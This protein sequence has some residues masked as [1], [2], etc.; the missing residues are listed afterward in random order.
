MGKHKALESGELYTVGW[1]AA[2]S[3]EMTAALAMLDERHDKPKD[4]V[5]PSSDTNAY[6]W[7]RIGDHNVVIASLA[8]GVYGTTSA[9][10]T[11]IHMLSSFPSIKVGLMVG[12]GAGIPGPNHDIR[13]GDVVVSQPHGQNGGV[14]QYDLG[15]SRVRTEQGNT[16]HTFERIGFLK[17]PPE[18]LLKALSLLK[19]E[20]RLD[21]SSVSQFLEDMLERHPS[22]AQSG[23]DGP[24]YIYQ[25]AE[26]DRLFEASYLHTS[27]IGCSGC[28]PART[29][30]RRARSN[31]SEP[32]VHY[33]VIASGNELVKNAAERDAI[34]KDN[35]G[36]CICLEME[37][38]GLMNS[39][40]CLVIRDICD[41]AD[42]HKND[43]WQEYAAAT[44]AAYAKE[45]LGYVD[46]GDLARTSKASE[47]LK[48]ISQDTRETNTTVKITQE[49]VQDLRDDRDQK[50][51]RKWLA[52]PDPSVNLTNAL[53]KRHED[54]GLWF[55][56][57]EAFERWKKQPN[58][59]LWL[60]GIPGCGKTVLSSTVIEHLKSNIEPDQPL[61]YFY[62]DFSDTNKQ[63]FEN[64]LRSLVNQLYQEQPKTRHHLDQIWKSHKGSNQQLSEP[65]LIAVLLAILSDVDKVSIVL[66]ALDESTA[67][68]DVTAWLKSTFELGP[69]C[70]ILVTA[71]REEDIMTAFQSWTRPKDR[72]SIQE[73]DIDGDIRAYVRHRVRNSNELVRWRESP[74]VQDEIES[75]LVEKADG[76]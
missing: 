64:M 63:T 15:K 58:S 24:G 40:P 31:P 23:S 65:S 12:I 2:L 47:I 8:A 18:A 21:G 22:L 29:I 72:I 34:L 73:S 60:H 54:T 62:F 57:G 49:A 56:H 44:A 1:I 27:D 61:L 28:D 71:R 7:G 67:R 75:K 76:M 70:R 26:H 48:E 42:S 36:D 19:A 53:E 4:F 35:G 38:A 69:I 25:G 66:D 30:P 11:A 33:G 45:F 17:P 59:F 10:T 9:A 46:N 13:L 16:V 41:Y 3:K 43:D 55:I 32:K 68:T 74:S 20:V 14:I 6:R 39:F 50:E 51:F 5:K 52:A 37:A